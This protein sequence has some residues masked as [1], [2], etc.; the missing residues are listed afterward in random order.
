MSKLKKFTV[1]LEPADV[2]VLKRAYPVRGYNQAIRAAVYKLAEAI[3]HRHRTRMRLLLEL[4]TIAK[5]FIF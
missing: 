3:R 4:H 1:R 2:S 5:T